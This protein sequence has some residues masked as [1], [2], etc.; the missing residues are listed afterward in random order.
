MGKHKRKMS[1]P[2]AAIMRM[3]HEAFKAKF[4]RE[5]GPKDPIFFDPDADEPRPMSEEK[6]A[7]HFDHALMLILRENMMRPE[8]VYASF[9]TR[10][11]LTHANAR[12]FSTTVRD[13]WE[14]AIDDYLELRTVRAKVFHVIAVLG[15]HCKT[16][17]QAEQIMR[18][19]RELGVEA[20]VLREAARKVWN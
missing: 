7:D 2:E 1:K 12:D 13:Q 19:A 17:A 15:V 16:P 10:K 4:G 20:E 14:E 18:K 3:Q 11:V 8:F 5:P 6:M 9:V